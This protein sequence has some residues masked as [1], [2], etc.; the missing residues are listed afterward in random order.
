MAWFLQ[1][2]VFD[3]AIAGL[4][5]GNNI[6]SCAR[7]TPSASWGLLF[8]A[9]KNQVLPFSWMLSIDRPEYEIRSTMAGDHR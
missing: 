5:D 7:R 4:D 6:H 2:K 1:V 8:A 3:C 9:Q